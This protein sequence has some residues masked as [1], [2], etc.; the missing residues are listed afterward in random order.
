MIK[1]FVI[2]SRI[3]IHIKQVTRQRSNLCVIDLSIVINVQLFS[4]EKAICVG[5]KCNN[6]WVICSPHHVCVCDIWICF[7]H[8]T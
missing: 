5:H 8:S 3:F 7:P 1:G 4:T 6:I 2:K